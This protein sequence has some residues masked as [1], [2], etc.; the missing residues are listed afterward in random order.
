MPR[1][2]IDYRSMREGEIDTTALT[3]ALD[4]RF[5]QPIDAQRENQKQIL[6]KAERKANTAEPLLSKL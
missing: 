3:T 1:E 6:E 2:E 4:R 5:S